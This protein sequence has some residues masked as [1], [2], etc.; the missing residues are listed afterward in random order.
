M[1]KYRD[2]GVWDAM[3]RKEPFTGLR[4]VEVE[5]LLEELPR[6]ASRARCGSPCRQ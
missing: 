4:Q 2:Q 3:K 6:S 5:N 1:G